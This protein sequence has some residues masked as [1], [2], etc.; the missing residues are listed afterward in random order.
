MRAF[1]FPGQ[2]TQF[3]GMGLAECTRSPE[4]KKIFDQANCILGR[5]ITQ[6]MFEGPEEELTKTI[7]AQLAVFLLSYVLY[8]RLF[9]PEPFCV[10]GHSLGEYTALA[11]SGALSFDKALLLINERSKAMQLSCEVNQGEMAAIVG[12]SL[13]TVEKICK[14]VSLTDL[15]E[16]SAYN[17][18]DNFT[19]SGTAH[20][21]REVIILARAEG[22][23]IAKK[24]DV[25]GPF[26]SQMMLPAGWGFQNAV[27]N[28]GIQ[29]AQVPVYVNCTGEKVTKGRDFISCLNQQI[30]SPVRWQQTIENMIADGV[31]EFVE[32]GPGNVLHRLIKKISREVVVSNI[33]NMDDVISFNVWKVQNLIKP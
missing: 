1:V 29:D 20:A 25:S 16:I 12:L 24:L 23:K 15:I 9:E 3:V 5:D 13:D 18:P 31:T 33:N 2:G 17:G 11:V 32:V 22:V 27:K 8:Q 4:I 30:T 7:N 28:I 10:A 26:H 6:V 14:E 19:V 21:V